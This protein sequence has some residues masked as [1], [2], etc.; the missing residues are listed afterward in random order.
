MM[1]RFEPTDLLLRTEMD[2]GNEILNRVNSRRSAMKGRGGDTY[3]CKIILL[4]KLLQE[5]DADVKSEL[6]KEEGVARKKRL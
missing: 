1:E 3:T 5:Q 6:S 2:G 4:T